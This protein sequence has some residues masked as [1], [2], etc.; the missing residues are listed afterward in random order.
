VSTWILFAFALAFSSHANSQG[1]GPRSLCAA[2]EIILD[3]YVSALGGDETIRQ[4]RTIIIRAHESEPHTFNPSSTAH[5]HYEFKWKSPNRVVAKRSLLFPDGAFIFDGGLWSNFNGRVSPNEDNTPKWLRELRAGYAYNDYPQFMMYRV[6]ADPFL[7]A[8]TSNLYFNLAV[9]RDS[10]GPG[11]CVLEA[12]G[13]NDWQGRRHDRLYF[14]AV[15]GFLKTWEIQIG[16]PGHAVYTRFEFADYRSV[17]SIQIPFSIY[18]DFYK[19]AFRVTKVVLNP[20]LR[21]SDFVPK[22]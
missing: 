2:P 4:V 1:S 18:F 20:D 19:A 6:V 16:S 8:S 22:R 5:S 10:S 13:L 7:I 11:T 14:D 17:G 12:T 15:N 21:D 9:D 3:R